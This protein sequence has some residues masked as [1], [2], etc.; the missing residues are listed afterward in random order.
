MYSWPQT[1]DALLQDMG[2]RTMRSG[3]NWL[4]WPFKPVDISEI[5]DLTEEREEKRLTMPVW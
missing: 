1:T 5:Q 3:G 4:T 2:L